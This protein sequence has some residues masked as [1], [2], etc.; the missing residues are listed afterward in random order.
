[1]SPYAQRVIR[2]V[3]AITPEVG[4]LW[5]RQAVLDSVQAALE[6]G[7]R[8]FQCRQ[9][10]WPMDELG[11]FV[12]DLCDVCMPYSAHLIVNDV[13]AESVV[14]WNLPG[15]DGV[16]LG[17]DDEPVDSARHTLSAGLLIG[18]SC[19]N[20]LD[21]AERAVRKGADYVAF[22]AVYPSTTK[23]A[24][25]RAPLELLGQA[26]ALGVPVVAIG[27]VALH[28]VAALRAAGA[29]AVA[30]VSGLFGGAEERPDALKVLNRARA[31]VE[32]FETAKP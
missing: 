8:L 12:A 22:G 28:N 26:R 6:G 24:A 23:P 31:W 19:Y 9:K 10:N 5:T 27:G 17:R 15:V 30:V 29:D 16:H 1:M 25:V 3:Y 32:E 11:E 4:G 20:E 7:V 18:A 21:R 2:G 14:H 13:S